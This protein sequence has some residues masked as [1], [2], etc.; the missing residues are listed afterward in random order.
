MAD[1]PSALGT[2][3]AVHPTQCAAWFSTLTV[4]WWVAGGWALDLYA[5]GQNRPHS[6]LDVGILRRDVREVL[7]ML[8]SWEVFEARAGALTRLN[9]GET[10]RMEVN[11]LWCRPMGAVQWVLELML[12]ESAEDSWV[13]RRRP[14][15]RRPLKTVTRRNSD[16][17]PYLAPEIQLLYKAKESRDRD[18]ADFD[19]IAPYLDPGARAWLRQALTRL[20]PGHAWIGKLQ[21]SGHCG[22]PTLDFRP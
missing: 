21:S 12:D 20:D 18:Q 2:W 9:A 13:F 15:I 17:L 11:S 4:P 5:G 19:H 10:P 16:G 1:N 8:S 22:L 6:D 14:D 3:Q 7:A